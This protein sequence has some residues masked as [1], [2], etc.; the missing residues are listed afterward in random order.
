M[1][2]TFENLKTPLEAFYHW[3]SSKP[4]AIFLRQPLGSELEEYTWKEVG[5]QAR[6]MAAHLRDLDLPPG[7]HIALFSKNCPHWIM[8]DLAIW[9]AGHVTVPLYP[10]LH[11]DTIRY[12]LTHGDC[13]LC[14]VGRLDRFESMREGIPEDLPCVSFPYEPVTGYENWDDI[15]TRND[16]IE[17]SPPRDLDEIAT[18]IYTSGTT[19]NPKG[20]VHKFMALSFAVTG[21]L[22]VFPVREE[23][24]FSYLPLSHVAERGMVEMGAIFTGSVV[25]FAD[26]LDTF[27]DNLRDG[28]PSLFLGV[29]RIWTKFQEKILEQVPPQR[30]DLMLRL[31]VIAGFLKSRMRAAL[32]LQNCRY[33]FSGAAPIPRELL[34]WFAGIGIEILEAYG[35]TENFA[36]SHFT[37]P[38][39]RRPGSVGQAVPRA[40]VRISDEGEIQVRSACNMVGYYKEPEKTA[41]AFD[42]AYLRTGDQGEIDEEGYLR[43][44]GRVKDLFKTAKGKYVAPSPI[45]LKIEKDPMVEQVCL[46]GVGIPQP[47]VLVQLSESARKLPRAEVTT[48]LENLVREVNPGLDHHERI[49][50]VVICAEPWTMDNK[51]LTPTLKIKRNVVEQMY[52]DRLAAWSEAGDPVIWEN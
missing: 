4:G 23:R 49:S 14:F 43:I 5:N 37:L 21:V 6:R 34:D 29:P 46:V 17:D 3:E 48:T 19:G 32:G 35:M 39:R 20:V 9:M 22:S 26:S 30:L 44:T 24:F 25:T 27:A 13:R 12:T 36:Y 38:G 50:H 1:I 45:E 7:S 51:V 11:P 41:E 10:T 52:S 47:L 28:A 16:P 15:V 31:P 2:S 42:G 33:G 18:I 8:A 40:D